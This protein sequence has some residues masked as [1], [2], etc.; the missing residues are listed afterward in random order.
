MN[1]DQ[2]KMTVDKQQNTCQF[3]AFKNV[4]D[5]QFPKRK[6]NEM[7]TKINKQQNPIL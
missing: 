6:V 3:T 2:G 7:F 5:C 1:K 4:F